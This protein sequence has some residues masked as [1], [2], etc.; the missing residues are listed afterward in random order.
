MTISST[1]SLD[2][3]AGDACR[4]RAPRCPR[5]SWRRRPRRS[6]PVVAASIDG[7]RSLCTPMIVMSGA[8][9]AGDDGHPGEQ[10]AAAGRDHE[11]VELGVVLEQLERHG[12]LAGDHGGVVVGVHERAALVGQ[13]PRLVRWPRRGRRR[14]ARRGRRAP[15][16]AAPS[17]TACG[18]A[19][20]WWP[21]CRAGWRG[22]RPPGRGCRPTSPRRRSAA[23]P[24]SSVRSLLSAPRSL[25]AAVNC[26]FSNFTTM[27]VPSTADSVCERALGVRSTAPAMRSAAARTSSRVTASVA[28]GD[29]PRTTS[30]S[31]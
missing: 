24:R 14:A 26:R 16:C 15:R 3:P 27:P 8:Q 1:S 30:A 19:S 2:Q 17:R 4:P 21:R 23:R 29:H 12:A 10:P 28:H 25:N 13:A 7:Q 22:G 31:P 11:R 20:R 6:V 9:G 18:P 5:R